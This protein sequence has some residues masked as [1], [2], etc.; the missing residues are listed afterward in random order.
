MN[1]IKGF[2]L[3][4]GVPVVALAAPMF[5]FALSQPPVTAPNTFNSVTSVIGAG[6]IIC[7]L[8]NWAFWLL[9]ILTVVFV[10]YAAFLYLTAAGDPEKVKAASHTL[11]YAAVAIIVALFAKGFPLIISSLVGSAV[12][13]SSC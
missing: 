5:A 9:T 11:L 12:S 13:G 2:A 3:K 1:R 10:L 8:V 6:G 7:V 4:F